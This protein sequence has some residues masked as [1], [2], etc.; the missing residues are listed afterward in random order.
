MTIGDAFTNYDG[1]RRVRVRYDT[2]AYA[3]FT[4]ATAYGRD[5]LSATRRTRSR[6]RR[7]LTYG[8][9]FSDDEVLACLGNGRG[10]TRGGAVTSALQRPAST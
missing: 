5:L 9:T 6:S 1:P 8:N 3:N 4:F 10:S 2:P 7:R